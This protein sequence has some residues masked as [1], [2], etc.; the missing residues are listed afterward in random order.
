MLWVGISYTQDKHRIGRRDGS[1]KT[2]KSCDNGITQCVIPCVYTRQVNYT[3]LVTFH[4]RK[5][6]DDSCLGGLCAWLEHELGE[7]GGISYPRR[8]GVYSWKVKIL[9]MKSL[10]VVQQSSA[11]ICLTHSRLSF[12]EKSWSEHS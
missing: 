6:L 12:N 2:Q 9:H 10:E 8:I 1:Q 7:R 3:R 11:D 5:Q 4:L